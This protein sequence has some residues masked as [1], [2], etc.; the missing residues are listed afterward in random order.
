M[1]LKRPSM[2]FFEKRHIVPV[3]PFLSFSNPP[4]PSPSYSFSI[5]LSCSVAPF[6]NPLEYLHSLFSRVPFLL[7]AMA[8][9]SDAVVNDAAEVEKLYE[10]GERLNEPKDKS[11]VPSTSVL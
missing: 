2:T 11:Q 5:P 1:P 10:L 4:L 8:S 7:A 6:F 3:T 9:E